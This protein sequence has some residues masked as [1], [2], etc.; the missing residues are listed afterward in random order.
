MIE[1]KNLTKRFDTVTAVDNL[2]LDI[3][4]GTVLGLVGSNGSGKSTLLRMLSGVFAPDEGEILLDG[5]SLFDNPAAKG[6]CYFIPD[7]PYFVIRRPENSSPC[8]SDI[9][10]P[11]WGQNWNS[12]ISD[13]ETPYRPGLILPGL[14]A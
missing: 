7:F 3:K 12:A 11:I 6:K 5:E 4:Q 14:C 1:F 13:A 9:G 8:L 10:T 2:C